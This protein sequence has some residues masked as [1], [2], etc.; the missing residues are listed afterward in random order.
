MDTLA[1]KDWSEKSNGELLDLAERDGY[2]AM[3]TTDQSLRDQQN[4]TRWRIG[5]VVVLSTNWF[6]IR[7]RT[8]QIAEAIEAVH[9]S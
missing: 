8:D 3:V 6:Q 5:L 4:L 7:L 1:E 9:S 2:R